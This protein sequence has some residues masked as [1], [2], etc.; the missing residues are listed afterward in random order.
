MMFD[1]LSET[2]FRE[3]DHALRVQVL[4]HKRQINPVMY[5]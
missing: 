2:G 5:S 4:V 1:A 3:A